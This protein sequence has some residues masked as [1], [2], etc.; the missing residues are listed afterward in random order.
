MGFPYLFR[1]ALDIHARAINEEMKIA[2]ATALAELARE[3][4][5]DEVA[6]A[7]GKE[8]KFGRD[9]IIPPPFD[10]NQPC[11][12]IHTSLDI[13]G[14]A[15]YRDYFEVG[16]KN[17]N[18]TIIITV[19][20]TD[21]I[22][23]RSSEAYIEVT[24]TDGDYPVITTTPFHPGIKKYDATKPQIIPSKVAWY[25]QAIVYWNVTPTIASFTPS[26]DNGGIYY[27]NNPLINILSNINLSTR[28]K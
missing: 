17:P 15:I 14:N 8:L 5:P 20:V 27:I 9:Y 12:D 3:D 1:G 16:W 21:P 2:C 24:T 11:Y 10:I 23:H 4:V 19:K 7:Y 22:T 28:N 13:S 18:I 26:K 6:L 25:D